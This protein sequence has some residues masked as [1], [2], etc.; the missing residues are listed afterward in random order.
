MNRALLLSGVH[1]LMAIEGAGAR[2]AGAKKSVAKSAKRGASA[3]GFSQMCEWSVW[4]NYTWD[5]VE[6]ESGH[7]C[8]LLN[9][10]EPYPFQRI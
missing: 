4:R 2:D 9:G 1:R 8:H 10:L 5:E 6:T 7:C 3:Q